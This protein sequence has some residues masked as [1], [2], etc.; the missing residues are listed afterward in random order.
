MDLAHLK[1]CS[2]SFFFY[3]AVN[4]LIADKIQNIFHLIV[5]HSG[6]IEFKLNKLD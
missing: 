4:K 5:E 3:L 6:F 2:L 1:G